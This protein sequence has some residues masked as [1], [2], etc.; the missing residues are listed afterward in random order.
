MNN[1]ESAI[2]QF[3]KE[4]RNHR[5]LSQ[6]QIAQ[7]LDVPLRTYQSWEKAY[8]SSA[9][10]LLGLGDF[11]HLSP[12]QFFLA[13][14]RAIK[15]DPL[16]P[17]ILHNTGRQIAQAAAEGADE[18]ELVQRFPEYFRGLNRAEA[19]NTALLDT[20]F[21]TSYNRPLLDKPREPRL[22]E[23]VAGRLNLKAGKVLVVDC[24]N[25]HFQ[26]LKEMALAP[27][28][29]GLIQAWS[30]GKPLFR[31]GISNG[32]TIARV[33]DQLPRQEAQNITLFPL[34]FTQTPADYPIST[35]SL[36]SAFMYRHEG[37][38]A[39]HR[40]MNE[41]EV[42]GAMML[43]DAA[44]LG[45][46]TL[47]Q[48]G[49]YSRMISATLGEA[50]REKVLSAGAIGDFNYYLIDKN[51][52]KKDFPKLVAPLGPQTSPALIKSIELELLGQKADR[53]CPVGVAAAGAHKAELVRLVVQKGY[54]NT[55]L[56]DST[57]AVQLLDG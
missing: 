56:L 57:L 26:T 21:S 43:A 23:A 30:Q 51:G 3:I 13:L 1:A 9:V 10:N 24:R 20:Y 52:E 2:A 6:S 34:N 17:E 25:L 16:P 31:L 14:H 49:L 45:I 28:G 42:Y 54:V 46:G 50:Y 33:L 41:S 7:A 36:I 39:E 15:G 37:R 35:T 22:E 48:K 8:T 38:C 12:D 32:Y 40:H 44:L 47:M 19:I 55:L 53:G 5:N 18:E 27:Y 29:A 11:Y 4:L